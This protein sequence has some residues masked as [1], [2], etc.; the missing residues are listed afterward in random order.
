MDP[1]KRQLIKHLID[2]VKVKR[3][4]KLEN[5]IDE[6]F[7]SLIVIPIQRQLRKRLADEEYMEL[8]K[9]RDDC[10]YCGSCVEG[11]QKILMSY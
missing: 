3:D 5:A 2:N 1:Y 4:S 7:A 11:R 6:V 8:V 9:R 10:G